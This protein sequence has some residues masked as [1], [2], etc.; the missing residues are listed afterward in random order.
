MNPFYLSEINRKKN[1]PIYFTYDQVKD[2]VIFR[3]TTSFHY[4]NKRPKS[5]AC[6]YCLG[7]VGEKHTI[8]VT[9]SEALDLLENFP[10]VFNATTISELYKYIYLYDKTVY[11]KLNN[12]NEKRKLVK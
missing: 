4:Y 8:P 9:L 3:A 12:R 7:T 11:D 1:K 6:L 10:T 2:I 5:I